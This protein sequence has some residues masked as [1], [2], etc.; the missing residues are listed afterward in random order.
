M[1]LICLDS[2]GWIE[3]THDGANAKTFAKALT[4][5]SPLIVSTISLYEIVRYTLRVAGEAAAE[6]L[7]ALLHQHTVTPVTAEIANLAATL[8][9]RHKLAM[10][11]ALIYATAQ[12]QHATLWTQDDDFKGLPHVKYFPKTEI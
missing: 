3:I 5:S 12:N 4:S 8:G 6:E 9:T 2:S 11:D 1:S 7:L 10:A